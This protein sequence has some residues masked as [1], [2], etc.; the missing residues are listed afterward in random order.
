MNEITYEDVKNSSEFQTYIQAGDQL[1]GT[2][3][4]TKHDFA[5]SAKVTET[6][7]HIL[8]EFGYEGRNIELAKIAS[9]IHDI[10]NMINRENHAQT[11]ALLAFQIL[12]GMGMPPEEIVLVVSAIG[13]HDEGSGSPVNIVSAALILADKT[14]VRRS[15][16]RNHDFATFDIHDRVNYAVE[17]AEVHVTNDSKSILL[18]LI[19]D[20]KI[21]SLMEYFEIFLTRMLLCRKA[22]D[23]LGA[24][25]ELIMNGTKIL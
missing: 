12:K 3:G 4:F 7:A 8:K 14:D 19:I 20:T 24:K 9:Y 22:A 21:C 25:F 18:N 10:G 23:F 17:K 1:L 2:M 6:S 13:N 15:R 16:V 5:H 11:G